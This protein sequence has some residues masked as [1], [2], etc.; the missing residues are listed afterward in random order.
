MGDRALGTRLR[1]RAGHENSRGSW[2]GSR[3]RQLRLGGGG[4]G[5]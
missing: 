5:E 3:A 4:G 1:L 2:S